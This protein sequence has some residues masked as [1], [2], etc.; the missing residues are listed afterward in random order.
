[1]FQKEAVEI[2]MG[3]EP[4]EEYVKRKTE[5]YI[6]TRERNIRKIHFNYSRRL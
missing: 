2:S 3:E 5:E 4:E 6:S 1:M